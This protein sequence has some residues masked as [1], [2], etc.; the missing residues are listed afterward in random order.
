[1]S[2]D[3]ASTPIVDLMGTAMSALVHAIRETAKLT[4]Q[5][6]TVIGG[7]AVVCRVSSPHR[8]TTDLDIVNH[9]RS[10]EPK[11]LELLVA[12]SKASGP[13][14][15]TV[16]TPLGSVHVDVLEVSDDDFS[17]LPDDPTARLFVLSHAWAAATATPIIIRAQDIGDMK[18]AVAE[19]GPLI[20][21]KLQSTFD[22][23]TDK[24]G[25]DLLDII[26]L[27]L[28]RG[29]GRRAREQLSATDAQLARDIGRHVWWCFEEHA[30]R[31]LSLINAI[32][33]GAGT[34]PDDLSLVR[35]LLTGA[36]PQ[37]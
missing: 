33:E 18:V 7:L 30:D 36:L 25:T 13:A 2:G 37:N 34:Q 19:P 27:T 20:A 4:N 10:D 22:R 24:E 15:A 12:G 17:P 32:P 8:A 31:S 1:V 29:A 9:R 14:G 16:S 11:Q 35:E 23:G 28:D 6:V 26:R 21:M 5:P 3:S